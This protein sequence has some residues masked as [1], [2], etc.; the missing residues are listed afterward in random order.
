MTTPLRLLDC[1]LVAGAMDGRTVLITGGNTGLGLETA[2]A[3]AREGA[4]VVF[5]S[6]DHR[7][8]ESARDESRR[9]SSND[10]VDVMELDLASLASVRE[11]APRF[12]EGHDRIDVL[13]NNAGLMLGSRRET[14]DGYEMTFQV[15]HL[16]PFLLTNRLPDPLVPG[17]PARVRDVAS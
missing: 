6:R 3:L 16:G 4:E 17:N 7:K 15:N 9:R 2:V 13:V 1:R 10:S 12:S 14:V 8:G 5:T 11:F